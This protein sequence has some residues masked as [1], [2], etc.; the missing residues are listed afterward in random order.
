MYWRIKSIFIVLTK[1]SS[2]VY[3]FI[4]LNV[5]IKFFT[6]SFKLLWYNIS[7]TWW[8]LHHI[9]MNFHLNLIK[10]YIYIFGS[11]RWF[12][13]LF[14]TSTTIVLKYFKILLSSVFFLLINIL[15]LLYFIHITYFLSMFVPSINGLI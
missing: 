12:L 8:I 7:C 9:I 11:R 15:S 14:Q 1:P 2:M 5:I 4:L 10:I 6:L 13:L 3:L